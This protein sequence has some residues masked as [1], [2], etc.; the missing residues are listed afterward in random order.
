MFIGKSTTISM[1]T[2]H[3]PSTRGDVF[4][5]GKSVRS[6]FTSA[7]RCMGV[8]TQDNSL[9]GELDAVAHLELFARVR[10]V[11]ESDIASLVHDSLSLMELNPHCRK[12][13][14]RLSGGMKRK[15]C[16]ALSLIGNPAVV[17][18][19]KNLC[20]LCSIHSCSLP[21]SHS[22]PHHHSYVYSL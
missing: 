12:P 10:G 13:S 9:Y 15:L 6:D 21:L 14:K 2:R 17:N 18:N 22:Y 19:K 11:P 3:T 7:A 8:V 20:I 1:M 4:V 5:M 16:T